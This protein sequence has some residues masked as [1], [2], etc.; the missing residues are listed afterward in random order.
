M[1][2]LLATCDEEVG[3]PLYLKGDRLEFAPPTVFGTSGAPICAIAAATLYTPVARI[4]AG[5]SADRFTRISCGGCPA[6]WALWNFTLMKPPSGTSLTSRTRKE[7]Q[8]GI[9]RLMIFNGV[10]PSRLSR[11]IELLRSH[12]FPPGGEAILAGSPGKDFYIVLQGEFEV[13]QYDENNNETVLA[14]LGQGECFGEMSLM[15]GEPASA[16]VRARGEAI[17]LSV[18]RQDFQRMLSLAPEMALTLARTLAGRLARTGR[19]V[20]EELKK[21]LLGRLDLIPPAEIIQAMCVNNQT[22]SL[23]VQNGDRNLTLY[24]QDGQL[25]E[26]KLE[27]KTGEEAF[28]EFLTWTRGSFQFDPVRKENPQRQMQSDTMG[29]LLEGLRRADEGRHTARE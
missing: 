2:R 26:A 25:L 3:C 17:A 5:E 12:R 15:T 28:Y 22:G 1:S 6:G 23:L 21:G 24:L 9:S 27:N 29:L 13:I 18:S 4:T 8:T 19:R 20:E 14:V 16:T 11:I 10:H 7:V